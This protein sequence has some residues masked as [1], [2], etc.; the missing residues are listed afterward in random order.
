MIGPLHH[1]GIAV[2]SLQAALARYRGFGILAAP[3]IDEVPSQ[4][5]RVA[6]LDVGGARV[7]FLE[8]TRPDGPI[9]RFLDARGE[10]LHHLAFETADIVSELARL[11]EAE[12]KLI[13]LEARPGAHGR[14]VAFVH[15]A[16]AHGVL[17]EIVQE[18]R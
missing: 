13:D 18:P 11:R 12:F 16:S 1:V 9:A 15:P 14:L 7:E 8:S 6:F 17:L 3:A 4:A 10:G 5:V 2:R